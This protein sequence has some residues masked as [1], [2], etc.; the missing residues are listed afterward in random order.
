MF[1]QLV[2]LDNW[3]TTQHSSWF[4]GSLNTLKFNQLLLLLQRLL[5]LLL[6]PPLLL[7]LLLL[8]SRAVSPEAER[9]AGDVGATIGIPD[10]Y[11]IPQ[12]C[13]LTRI[14]IYYAY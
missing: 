5:L 11:T 8:P 14:R 9:G 12:G 7:K 10:S 13:A 2:R 6:S 4:R 3:T 1:G